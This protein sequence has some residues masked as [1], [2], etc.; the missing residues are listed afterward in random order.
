MLQVIYAISAI[1][2]CL[3]IAYGFCWPLGLLGMGMVGL[4][5]GSMLFLAWRIYSMNL[6]AVKEDDAGRVRDLLDLARR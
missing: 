6:Q 5:M 3:A 1:T 2:C 4:L